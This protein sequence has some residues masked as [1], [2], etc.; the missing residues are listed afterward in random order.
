M[1]ERVFIKTYLS[2]AEDLIIWYKNIKEVHGNLD[3]FLVLLSVANFHK[4][5]ITE[6]VE[7]SPDIN[8]QEL[9]SESIIAR[10]PKEKG[11][12]I[13]GIVRET[14]IP[15]TTVKRIID[16][17]L[18]KEVFK[19]TPKGLITIGINYRSNNKNR[20]IASYH[21]F[22]QVAKKTIAQNLKLIEE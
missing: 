15:R 20:R 9:T 12:S 18:E 22:Q 13:N 3:N 10:I 21:F 5:E 19:K 11:V 14:G 4:K 2:I 16:Q 17:Y 1:D 8:N 7:G 6:G